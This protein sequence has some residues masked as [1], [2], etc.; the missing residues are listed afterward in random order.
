MHYEILDVGK[1][2][3]TESPRAVFWCQAPKLFW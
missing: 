1:K 3:G 2:K